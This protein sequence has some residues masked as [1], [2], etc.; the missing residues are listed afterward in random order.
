MVPI[1][2]M[3]LGFGHRPS[4]PPHDAAAVAAA[5]LRGSPY[6]ALRDVAC[7]MRGSVLTLRGRVSSYY[8]KQLAQTLLQGI[9]EVLSV[10]N[11]L[12]VVAAP[13]GASYRG[14][15]ASFP[16]GFPSRRPR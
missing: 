10:D 9:A 2:E 1:S 13:P 16:G 5:R 14:Q 4:L 3:D 15:E 7:E 8:L 11:Q 12:D 6:M